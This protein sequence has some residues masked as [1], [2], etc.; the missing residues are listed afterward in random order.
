MSKVGIISDI[1]GNL[2]AM[3]AVTIQLLEAGVVEIVC[4][5][6][7]V[8]YGAN[9]LEIVNMM[10]LLKREGILT[11]S[12]LGNHDKAILDGDLSRFRTEHGKHS[13][14]WSR[15]QLEKYPHII[16]MLEGLEFNRQSK[17]EVYHGNEVDE[18]TNVFVG[19]DEKLHSL[20]TSTN[21]PIVV[22]GHSHLQF[23]V[24]RGDKLIINPGSVGQPRNG[25]SYAQ[26][27][28]VDTETLEYQLLDTSYD[29]QLSARKIVDAG[30]DTFLA[31][32][33]YLGI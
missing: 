18:W 10:D 3:I 26:Y 9:P 20:R 21:K 14:N 6:D 30:L 22:I 33:L 17:I 24:S 7:Y 27:A 19:D 29:I 16:S 2:E 15:S 31:T 12:K 8:D 13:A 1:H 23:A 32:R 28:I 25:N 4:A 11:A 5:G